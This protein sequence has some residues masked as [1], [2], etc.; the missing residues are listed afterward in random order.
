M[1]DHVDEFI[2]D[3]LENGL[4]HL[5]CAVANLSDRLE[6][7]RHQVVVN[8]LQTGDKEQLAFAAFERIFSCYRISGK[9]KP[10]LCPC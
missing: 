8:N 5:S 2:A 1:L 9:L 4:D 3:E 10:S 7:D 6:A